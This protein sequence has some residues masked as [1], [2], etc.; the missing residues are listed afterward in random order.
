MPS[1]VEYPLRCTCDNDRQVSTLVLTELGIYVFRYLWFLPWDPGS[2]CSQYF[3]AVLSTLAALHR[4][5]SLQPLSAAFSSVQL[6]LRSLLDGL[7]ERM[8]GFNA[9]VADRSGGLPFSAVGGEV[10]AGL[11]QLCCPQLEQSRWALQVIV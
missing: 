3:S 11:M 6:C 8:G 2:A 7:S 9:D 5:S 10:D 1:C 4:S